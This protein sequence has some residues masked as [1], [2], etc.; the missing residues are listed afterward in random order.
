MEFSRYND[1]TKIFE[2]ISKVYGRSLSPDVLDLWIECLKPFT[3]DAVKDAMGQFVQ[4]ESRMPVPADILKI[5]RGTVQDR[6]LSALV[7]VETA[8]RRHGAYTTVV[9]DDPGIHAAI[10]GLGGW[11]RLCGLTET[12][13]VWWR[14]DF[15]ERYEH[16]ARIGLSETEIPGKLPGIFELGNMESGFPPGPPVMIGDR[17]KCLRLIGEDDRRDDRLRSLVKSAVEHGAL[18]EIPR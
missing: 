6:S 13:M 15:R 9:F 8:V 18:K 16:G 17:D 2:K 12:E 5:L 7:K 4:T 14:K 10:A 3:F 1:F 11:I